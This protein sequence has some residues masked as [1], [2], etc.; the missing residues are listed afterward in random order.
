[1]TILSRRQMSRGLATVGLVAATG[2]VLGAP[3]KLANRVKD[4]RQMKPGEFTWHPDR[5]PEGPVSIVV[6]IPDQRVHVYRNA[7]RIGVSTCSTGK[8]GHST[9]TGVF[10]ILQ[11]DKH[12]HSSTYNNA[13]M[14]NM[15]RL[16]WSGIALHAG[17]LPGY[18][19]SHGCIRL[20]PKF[21]ELLF[22]VTHVGTPVI[23]A[24][25]ATDPEIIV[26]PGLVLSQYATHE[27]DS[28]KT[29]LAKTSKN[30]WAPTVTS[31]VGQASVLISSA[32]RKGTLIIDGRIIG[33][34]EVQ[35][36]NP[37]VP[38]GSHVFI[39]TGADNDRQGMAWHAI[40]YESHTGVP[41]GKP[42]ESVLTRVSADRSKLDA[43]HNYMHAGMIL[44]TTDLPAHAETRTGR[45]FV[46][47]T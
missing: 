7:I 40:G 18:P 41:A 8:K 31:F 42:T 2:P 4:L 24:G 36:V 10:T 45:D 47:M 26:H 28:V 6:S 3:E 27:F 23:V 35:I 16:T 44:V 9:P 21:S 15:N 25:G 32:D 43:L 14:P 38:L 17:H 29:K 20:P 39:L 11:K 37:E 22:N 12:H 34:A 19:A 30:P 46:I 13:P 1:M 5:S 33:E